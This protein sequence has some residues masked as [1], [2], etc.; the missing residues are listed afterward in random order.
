MPL[1]FG[2]TRLPTVNASPGRAAGTGAEAMAHGSGVRS[3]SPRRPPGR[4]PPLRATAAGAS[5]ALA[6][7]AFGACGGPPGDA[8]VARAAVETLLSACAEGQATTAL[9]SLTEPAR[10]AFGRGRGTAE[11][12][13][14]VLG[15]ELAPL[16]PEDAARAFEEARVSAVEASGGIAS[17][18]VEV[19]GRR[20]ELEVERVGGRWLVNNP[21]VPTE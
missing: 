1:S 3:P 7:L 8:A 4:R 20:R 11:S 13:S 12:C 21:A 6:A 17:A 2:G 16:S 15:L 5:T 14:E 19:A 18:T 9:E 10:R